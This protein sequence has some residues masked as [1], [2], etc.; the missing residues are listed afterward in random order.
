MPGVLSWTYY[1][2]LCFCLFFCLRK[3][4][5]RYQRCWGA[6]RWLIVRLLLGVLFHS[7][8]LCPFPCP[9]CG[10]QGSQRTWG[11]WRGSSRTCQRSSRLAIRCIPSGFLRQGWRWVLYSPAERSWRKYVCFAV[12]RLCVLSRL[13]TQDSKNVYG[14]VNLVCQLRLG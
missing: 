14:R 5:R 12:D 2:G 6:G 11:R 7:T 3:Q 4:R 9:L 8:F 13:C 1:F 10:A